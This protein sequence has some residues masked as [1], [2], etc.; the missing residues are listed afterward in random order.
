[1]FVNFWNWKQWLIIM[2]PQYEVSHEDGHKKSTCWHCWKKN[3]QNARR[4][5]PRKPEAN[6]DAGDSNV[7]VIES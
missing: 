2:N 7:G 6:L 3:D 4:R 5:K 1:M